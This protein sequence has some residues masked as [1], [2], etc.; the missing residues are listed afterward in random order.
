MGKRDKFSREDKKPRK[1]AVK[2][3]SAIILPMPE[4]EVARKKGKKEEESEE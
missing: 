4:V 3:V 2:P 1:G